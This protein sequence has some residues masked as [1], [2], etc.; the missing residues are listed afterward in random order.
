M[1]E[2]LIDADLP[3]MKLLV[4]GHPVERSGKNPER[5]RLPVGVHKVRFA[6]E[7]R[8]SLER[9]LLVSRDAPSSVGLYAREHE[10]V[11]T[12]ESPSELPVGVNGRSLV[13]P[14]VRPTPRTKWQ[15]A[16]GITAAAV[17]VVALGAATYEGLHSKSLVNSANNSFDQNGSY[18][19]NDL[20]TISSARSAATTANVLFIAGGVLAAS[21]LV[22]TFAF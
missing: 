21:G 20:S 14:S 10:E 1:G 13:E 8:T 9:P 3:E 5:L 18:T 15:R 17:G 7:G 2:A 12:L 11:L 16:V 22:L 4:D 6:V 19:R